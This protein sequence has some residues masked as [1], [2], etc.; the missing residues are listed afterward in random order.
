VYNVGEV[1]DSH[2]LVVLMNWILR[3]KLKTFLRSSLCVWPVASMAAALLAAPLILMVDERT[4]WTLMGFGPEGSRIVVGALASSLLTFIVFAFSIIL[5]A[6]QIAGG[7]L[8]PRIIARVFESHLAKVTLSAF[9]FSY[10][11]TLA[12]LGRIEDRVPQLPIQVA[13]IASL[14]SVAL[15]LYLI[16][17][18]SQSLRPVMILTR[19]AADT[20]AVINSVYP[21][22][23]EVRSAKHPGP[24]PNILPATRTIVYSGRSGVVIA[25]DSLGLMKKAG[26]AGVT[27]ELVPQVGDFLAT[28]EEVFRLYGN[29]ADA[30]VEAN[31]LQCIMLGSER[32]LEHDPAFGFRIIVDIA[33]KALSP[34][35]NDPTTG[36]LAVDQIE[37]LLHL[38]GDREIETGV[39]RDSSGE[40]RLMYRTPS[41]EDFV[42]LAVTEIRLYG[43]NSPQVTRR[44]MAMFEHLVKVLP[45][46][47]SEPLYK[48]LALLQRT[49]DGGFVDPE[50]RSLAAV[51]DRQG[52]GSRQRDHNKMEG[53]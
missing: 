48:E 24:D 14:L 43:A 33:E 45:A 37:H 21:S 23:F 7:Q 1:L 40:I 29:G 51:G 8:S 4:Q 41:W 53:A 19:V 30:L 52:F 47:R 44:L 15:F 3:Y 22:P 17:E 16:Q 31:L 46:Q 2:T 6:V 27:I 38:L 50:D 13:I 32:S 28:G 9:V 11:Y 10:T 20:R 12:A 39:V 34:A 35:I 25:F 18:V 42:D 49:I 26:R 36:V 5:L